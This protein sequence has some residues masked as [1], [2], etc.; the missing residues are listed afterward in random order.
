MDLATFERLL[1]PAGRRVLALAEELHAAGVDALRAGEQVRRLALAEH[2]DAPPGAAADLAAAATT[3]AV[4]RARAVARLGPGAARLLLT[5]DGLQQATRPEI[6]DR[7]AA[8]LAAA[9]RDDAGPHGGPDATSEAPAVAPPTVMDL[10]C[11]IGA[12][13][14]AL[15]RARLAVA[16]VDLDPVTAAVAAA[17]F[18]AAPAHGVG[19][20]GGVTVADATTVD[21]SAYDAVFVDPARR[22]ARGRTFDVD[23][24]SP[25]WS[26]VEEV[27]AGPV[28]AV[29]K[30]APGVPHDRIPAGVEAEWV[31]VDGEVK[32]AALWSPGLAQVTRRATVIRTRRR[33]DPGADATAPTPAY[34]VE[35]V[36]DRDDPGPDA[37]GTGPVAA[38]LL[39]PD[40]AVV[41]A[42][43]VTAVAALVG[44]HLL[45][46]HI[47]YVA[48]DGT[49][50]TGGTGGTDWPRALR[51][52]RAYRV[53]EELPYQEKRLKAALRERGIGRLTIKKRGVQA[54]PEELRRRLA[55]RGDAEGTVVLTRVA[56]RGTALLV[57]PLPADPG[58]AADWSP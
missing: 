42:G 38:Y 34:D 40:G 6:A 35:E 13:L 23:A 14:L 51:L 12:D 30:V 49:G 41:R 45:D 55:L 43:L 16:G 18:A 3:Q 5:P 58:D 37:V 32:E 19:T 47:A 53:Q 46:E 31:S 36:T 57:D 44:G 20:R 33:T 15:A 4:L 39:E 9:L 10:G 7:R 29:V 17:N 22:T 27:L 50:G 54:V 21:R 28:P 52:A 2:A 26:F 24:Y 1:T 48:A 25:P 8:R 11:G 56:G